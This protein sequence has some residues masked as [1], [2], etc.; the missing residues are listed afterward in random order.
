MKKYMK[1]YL[2]R[3]RKYP[4]TYRKLA[5]K[6]KWKSFF[7]KSH[8]G[9][10]T[11]TETQFCCKF[12]I[13]SVT[14]KLEGTHNKKLQSLYPTSSM[15]RSNNCLKDVWCAL[16]T[17]GFHIHKSATANWENPPFNPPFELSALQ[18]SR[19]FFHISV[20]LAYA[21]CLKLFI[22]LGNHTQWYSGRYFQPSTQ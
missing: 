21:G 17:N 13:W 6:S 19:R 5:L 2:P 3:K 8:S 20:T 16:R 9:L 12:Y 7:Q 11:N 15:L 14:H 10:V 1:W 18:V 4:T 22:C